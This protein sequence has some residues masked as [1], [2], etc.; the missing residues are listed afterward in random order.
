MIQL[1]KDYVVSRSSWMQRVLLTNEAN[2]PQTPVISYTGAADFPISGLNFATSAFESPIGADFSG[3]KWRIAEVTDPNAPGFDPYDRS[4]PRTYEIDAT[5]ESDVLTS[6]DPNVQIPGHLLQPG[7]T[8]RVRVRMQDNDSHWSHW[9]EPI[10]F[11]ATAGVDSELAAALRISEVNYNPYDATA[12]EIAAGITDNNDFE[13]IE[14]VNIG[15]QTLDLS[16]ATLDRLQINGVEQGLEF[17]F[18]TGAVTQLAPGQHA[19][20]VENLAAFQL[21][22]GSDLPVA[23]QWS[24]RLSNG[25]ETLTLSAFGTIIQQFTYDDGWHQAT[26]GQGATLE[27]INPANPDLSSW[28][29]PTA[30]QASAQRGGTP[31][32]GPGTEIPGDANRDGTFNSGD[33]VAVFQ[34]GEYEDNVAGNSTWEDGDWDGDGDFSTADIVL[35]FQFGAY[36]ADAQPAATT[37]PAANRP[38]DGAILAAALDGGAS[39][40]PLLA[41]DERQVASDADRRESANLR[42]PVD[43]PVAVDLIFDEWVEKLRADDSEE[44]FAPFNGL[45]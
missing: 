12:A 43:T 18:A 22:Y 8:Y 2:I 40:F 35:A 26:D 3:M 20:V 19:V 28:N 24:G 31:G 45:T 41:D 5:W 27:L 32:R 44:E 25:S 21:R 29:Q 15:S 38:H 4:G 39:D 10:Q 7:K 37:R 11:T 36:V 17:Q 23:G 16:G 13:F 1:M 6:F 33:L 30:W 14:L 34:I 42:R 9:S